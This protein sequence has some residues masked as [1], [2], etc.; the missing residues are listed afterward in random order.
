MGHT[1]DEGRLAKNGK[2]NSRP[3]RQKRDFQ[4]VIKIE[5]KGILTCGLLQRY[6]IG[7]IN[8]MKPYLALIM[9]VKGV[10]QGPEIGLLSVS[11]YSALARDA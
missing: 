1:L 7:L 8:V 10:W 5:Q 3:G 11:I 6:N 9:M 4:T 2:W